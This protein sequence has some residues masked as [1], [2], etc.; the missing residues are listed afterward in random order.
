[1]RLIRFSLDVFLFYLAYACPLIN[2]VYALVHF[3]HPEWVHFPKRLDSWD[4]KYNPKLSWHD[5]RLTTRSVIDRWLVRSLIP[6]SLI[7]GANK[8]PRPLVP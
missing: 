4:S 6:G 8:P 2:I 7:P 1:M 5:I 3:R